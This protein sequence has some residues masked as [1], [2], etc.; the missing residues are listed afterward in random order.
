MQTAQASSPWGAILSG[1]PW[2]EIFAKA[3]QFA[4]QILFPS[5]Q[6]LYEVLEYESTLEMLDRKGE[7][8]IFKKRQ[9]VRYLQDNI[10]AY[11]DQAWGD[12]KFL[13]DYRCSPGAAVDQYR[14][15]HKTYILI[16]LREV[17]HRG[18]TDEFIIERK[19]KNGFLRQQEQWETDINHPTRQ[20]VLRL[21][22]PKGRPPM[23][24][25][26]VENIRQK[27][28]LVNDSNQRQ[29]PD[30]RWQATWKTDNPRLNERY[31]L[32]WEW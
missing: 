4:R 3:G 8:A 10:I 26:M 23:Q 27:T 11:M 28:T 7:K 6:G 29:L 22:F 5:R 30:G 24:V 16:S 13:V 15:G 2:M 21:I 19:I 31:V 17:K 9:K 20:V 12:G 18:D 14:F 25:E 32:K 1:L